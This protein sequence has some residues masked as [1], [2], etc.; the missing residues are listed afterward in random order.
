MKMA[1]GFIFSNSRLPTFRVE[2]LPK[3]F[4]VI[5]MVMRPFL[6]RAGPDVERVED[7][8]KRP[9]YLCGGKARKTRLR[10]FRGRVSPTGGL[11]SSTM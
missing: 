1:E 6:G 8:F 10:M 2:R 7:R 9:L 5:A 11:S 3:L 4:A